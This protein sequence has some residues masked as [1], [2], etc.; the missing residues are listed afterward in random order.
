MADMTLQRVPFTKDNDN[1]MRTLKGRTGITP[2]LLMT[3][4]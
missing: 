4:E 1:R 2:N 3:I